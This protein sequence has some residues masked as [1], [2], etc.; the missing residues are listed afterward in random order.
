MMKKSDAQ[1]LTKLAAHLLAE[2]DPAAAEG[3][4]EAAATLDP[5]SF[6]AWFVLAVARA[7]QEDRAG[8]VFAYL[9]ALEIVPGHI[10]CWTDL[11]ELYIA[12]LDYKRAAAALRQ[13]MMLDPH[14]LNPAGR[15]ARAVAGKTMTRLKKQA[16]T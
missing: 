5:R 14:A 15:R 8:A 1:A 12:L 4:A 2:K 10:G 13:A 7:R 9:Q 16:A 3:A 11:G 6:D